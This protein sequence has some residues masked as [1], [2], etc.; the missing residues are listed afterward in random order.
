MVNK[1]NSPQGDAIDTIRLMECGYLQLLRLVP[2][3]WQLHTGEVKILPDEAMVSDLEIT[4]LDKQVDLM[5]IAL[6]YAYKEHGNILARLEMAITVEKCGEFDSGNAAAIHCRNTPIDH[7]RLLEKSTWWTGKANRE[8]ND[9]LDYWLT[10]FMASQYPE[11][12]LT[13]A[14]IHYQDAC[15]NTM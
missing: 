9:F 7:A 11:K 13:V 8:L 10:C 4:V 3:L 12:S 5:R 14:P 1:V 2:A 15:R 6:S